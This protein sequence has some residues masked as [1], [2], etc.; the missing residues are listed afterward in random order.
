MKSPAEIDCMQR[1]NDITIAAYRAGLA[2]LHEGMTQFEL[3][4][5]I[6]AAYRA[7]G[8]QGEVA[9]S[10]GKDTAFPHGSI[11]PQ[12]LQT[13]DAGQIDEG[14]HVDGVQYDNTPKVVFVKPTARQIDVWKLERMMQ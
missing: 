7:L 13:G 2:T 6:E 11:Q 10:F 9:V 3:R 4:N 5:N 12:K 14:C 8:V 1:A